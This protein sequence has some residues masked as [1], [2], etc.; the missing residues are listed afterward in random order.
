[1]KQHLGALGLV[2]ATVGAINVS[3]STIVDDSGTARNGKVGHFSSIVAR[4]G[5]VAISYYCEEDLAGNPPESYALRFAWANGTSWQWTTVDELGGG[6]TSMARGTDGVYQIIY[7]SWIGLGW[8]TG[9][10]TTWN[11]GLVDLPADMAPA[12]ISMVL[13]HNNRPHVAYMNLTNGGDHS[14]RYA[15]H[16]GTQ[17]VTDGANAGIVDLDLWRP[18]IGFS[19]TY[20]QLDA[21]DT[22]HVV[23]SLPSDSVNVYGQIQYATLS[24]GPGG[25]WQA[26]P[27]GAPGEDP[28]LAFGSD[29]LPRVA[30]NGDAGLMYAYKSGG[31]WVFETVL[32]G[33]WA[34]S[35]SM[36]LSDT[37]VPVLTFGHGAE[38]DM[39]VARRESGGWTVTRIDGDGGQ[40]WHTVGH[41]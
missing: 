36:A 25:T 38:E 13:D 28:T 12:N 15:F 35:L 11:L 23:Y 26:E 31:S 17:W 32:P 16:D 34:S 30:F 29:D 33:Q 6:D 7:E 24:G 39:Y 1:M 20:L 5:N 10:G 14:L 22:P 8:A 21:A 2:V 9:S 37:D 4:G 3:A 41:R 18:T 27:I 19:N 40:S